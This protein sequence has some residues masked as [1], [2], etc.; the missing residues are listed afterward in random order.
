[1]RKLILFVMIAVLAVSAAV[2]KDKKEYSPGRLTD[3]KTQDMQSS[4]YKVSD[5]RETPINAPQ[6]GGMGAGMSAGGGSFS[7]APPHFI[8]YNL[9][10]ETNEETL[11][12]SR[13]RE[14]SLGQPEFKKDMELQ[15]RSEGPK[16]VEVIDAKGKKFEMKVMKRVKKDAPA[17]AAPAPEKK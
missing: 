15:W 6:S 7:S 1:M 8:R 16:A 11:Y 2:A 4:N 9:V 13:D 12:L 10:I 17:V 14:I 5:N 3:Y